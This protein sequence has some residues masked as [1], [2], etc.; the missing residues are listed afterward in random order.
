[1]FLFSSPPPLAPLWGNVVHSSALR[2]GRFD[3]NNNLNTVFYVF[4]DERSWFFHVNPGFFFLF[5]TVDLYDKSD[6]WTILLHIIAVNL[7]HHTFAYRSGVFFFLSVVH[8]SSV[9]LPLRTLSRAGLRPAPGSRSKKLTKI[10]WHVRSLS[11]SVCFFFLFFIYFFR[12]EGQLHFTGIILDGNVL[13]IPVNCQRSTLSSIISD[14]FE[15]LLAA[16]VHKFHK[17]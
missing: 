9:R 11:P 8:P 14:S 16:S 12:T 10:T 2:L 17:R 7:F 4:D 6:V 13:I 1:M 5:R 15:F 3:Y